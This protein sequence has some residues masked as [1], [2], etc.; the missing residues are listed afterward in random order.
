MEKWL[1][2]M[3]RLVPALALLVLSRVLWLTIRL[4]RC[5]IKVRKLLYVVASCR[6][7]TVFTQ[8]IRK[9]IRTRRPGYIITL[10]SEEEK[11]RSFKN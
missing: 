8:E 3:K 7:M 11:V 2:H 9:K 1:I 5:Q 4:P 6:G 10:I